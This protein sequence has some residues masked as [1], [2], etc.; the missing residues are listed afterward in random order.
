MLRWNM[1]KY[2][3]PYPP[4]THLLPSCRP[5]Y[6]HKDLK[7]YSLNVSRSWSEQCSWYQTSAPYK[8]TLYQSYRSSDV[9]AQSLKC[10]WGSLFALCKCK[11]L[12][13]RLK[14]KLFALFFQIRQREPTL[15]I[16]LMQGMCFGI[17]LVMVEMMMMMVLMM[18][19]KMR[20]VREW[21]GQQLLM[22]NTT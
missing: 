10:L 16:V 4:W 14:K 9:I 6:P 20:S 11:L 18:R 2:T 21:G 15:P 5:S 12:A 22:I 7:G 13:G 3:I 8:L 17:V 1:R 19:K